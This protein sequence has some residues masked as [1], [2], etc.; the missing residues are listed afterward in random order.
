MLSKILFP[1]FG[2]FISILFLE[3]VFSFLPVNRVLPGQAVNSI[4]PYARYSP[5]RDFTSSTGSLMDQPNVI[6]TNNIG[7]ISP[8][9][10]QKNHKLPLIAVI[11]DSFVEAKRVDQQKTFSSLLRQQLKSSHRVYTF[12]H[13]GAPLSQYLAYAKFAIEEYGAKQLIFIV[14]GNDYDESLYRYKQT[15]RFHFFNRQSGGKLELHRIDYSPS[16]LQQ[17]VSSSAFFSYLAGNLQLGEV[18]LSALFSPPSEEDLLLRYAANTEFDASETR[19]QT[20]KLAV[21]AFLKG[22]S[23]LPGIGREDVLFVV[24]AVRPHIYLDFYREK[25]KESFAHLMHEYL[26]S[27]AGSLDFSVIDLESV[28][29]ERFLKDN[30]RFETRTNN[31]WSEYGHSVVANAIN[32]S[33]WC[34]QI[35]QNQP[36]LPE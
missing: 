16:F 28:F 18:H 20:S 25:V 10:Y 3:I 5:N 24:D 7:L 32:S 23:E 1:I 6:H 11:G 30:K 35:I 15:P 26:K 13:S 29:L 17:V 21:D 14:V 9:D 33:K 4:T 8:V 31:H 19:M 22:V 34:A 2:A 12:A 36:V 27:Q